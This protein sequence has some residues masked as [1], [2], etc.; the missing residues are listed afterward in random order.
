MT[1]IVLAWCVG[2]LVW[3][4]AGGA[5]NNCAS[6]TGGQ[7]LSAHSAQAACQAGT[8]LGVA[9][10]LGIGFFG[11]VFLSLIWLMTGRR[12]RDCP[13]CGRGVKRGKTRCRACGHDFAGAPTVTAQHS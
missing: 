5:S 10:I 12:K 7:Y 1:W 13:V 9:I 11:F 8:G 4:I 6:Q 3:A 2:I